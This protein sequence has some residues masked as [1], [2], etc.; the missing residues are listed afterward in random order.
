MIIN[1]IKW[2]VVDCLRQ[3][4]NITFNN[5]QY[6]FDG[7]LF[8]LTLSAP[9]KY[10]LITG[11]NALSYFIEPECERLSDNKKTLTTT[12]ECALRYLD[13]EIEALATL[14]ECGDTDNAYER[15]KKVFDLQ[16]TI[17][18]KEEE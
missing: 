18:L 12:Q 11:L 1:E 17:L 3:P 6:C 7:R 10:E 15:I 2:K 16:K 8:G 9:D 14:M 13:K 4:Y 5:G